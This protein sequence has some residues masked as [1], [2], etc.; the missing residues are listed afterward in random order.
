VRDTTFKGRGEE[1][2]FSLP[3][4]N[5]GMK[6]ERKMSRGFTAHDQN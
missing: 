4:F 1:T 3:V 2:Y 5:M 6:S